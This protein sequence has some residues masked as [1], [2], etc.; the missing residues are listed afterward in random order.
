MAAHLGK[1]RQKQTVLLVCWQFL[2]FRQRRRYLMQF[3]R[4][5][6]HRLPLYSWAN[7]GSQACTTIK[8]R[9]R[10]GLSVEMA[11]TRGPAQF[12]HRTHHGGLLKG[13]V[14]AQEPSTEIHGDHHEPLRLQREPLHPND[15]LRAGQML[16][17]HSHDFVRTFDWC[18]GRGDH[19]IFGIVHYR[20]FCRR[21]GKGYDAVT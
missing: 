6:V 9:L 3:L 12:V 11:L 20:N 7:E 18:S 1:L 10:C 14:D 21:S 13:V 19:A 2:K 5:L 4:G 15:H 8:D 16:D 17:A